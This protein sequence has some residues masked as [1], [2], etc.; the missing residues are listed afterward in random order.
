VGHSMGVIRAYEAAAALDPIPVALVIGF[1]PTRPAYVS[2]NVETAINFFLEPNVIPVEPLPG[3]AGVLLNE[4]V[5][6]EDDIDHGEIIYDEGLRSR[7]I[8]EI[9]SVVR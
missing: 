5:G 3:F 4:I 6:H 1:D 7:A 2:P 8:Q 9:Q